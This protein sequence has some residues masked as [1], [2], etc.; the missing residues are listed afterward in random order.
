MGRIRV[1]NVKH[2]ELHIAAMWMGI[3][4]MPYVD[5][6][7]KMPGMMRKVLETTITTE[8]LCKSSG[9]AAVTGSRDEA[10]ADAQA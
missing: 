3:F 4:L 2:A 6:V 9:V 7:W 1:F 5:A 8:K 10:F